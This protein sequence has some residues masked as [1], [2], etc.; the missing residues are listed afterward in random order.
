VVSVARWGYDVTAVTDGNEAWE[1][2]QGGERF[3]LAILDWMMPGLDGPELC[4]LVRA[5][6]REPY[7]YIL[8]LTGKTDTQD[9]VAGL[10]AGADDYI[11]KPFDAHELE[12][13][14]RVGKRIVGLQDDLRHAR[15]TMTHQAMHDALTGLQSRGAALESLA[16]E[17]ARGQR[18]GG[19]VGVVLFDVDHFKRVNDTHGH[20]VGDAV[21]VE[22]AK[23]AV[24]ATRPEDMVGRY[25]GEEF[26]LVLPGCDLAESMTVA[27]RLRASLESRPIAAGEKR[28]L[29]VTASF[30]VVASRA[31]PGA[32]AAELIRIADGA[33]YEAKAAG[34]DCVR[35]GSSATPPPPPSDG[36][37]AGAAFV[38]PASRTGHPD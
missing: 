6:A 34:R 1:R 16:R 15:D 4:R 26:L 25:G 13:R 32:S 19:D 30:G 7:V 22:V 2:L 3:S 36:S 35:A 10:S 12:V 20:A 27:E 11:A 8:L 17:L 38:P 37:Q 33:L 31:A 23:R 9:V 29:R 21:L 18:Q 28:D 24:E 5:A 14:L